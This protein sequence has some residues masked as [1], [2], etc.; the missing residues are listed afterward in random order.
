[1]TVSVA[2]GVAQDL[3]GNPNLASNTAT[4]Q[5]VVAPGALTLDLPNNITRNNDP[6]QP[7]AVV[8]FTATASGGVP[9]VVVVCDP[10]SGAFFAIGAT[11]VTCI[12]TDG[13]E[14]QQ[15]EAIVS[16]TFTVTVVDVEPP[17]I[18]DLPDLT[19]TT[20]DTTPVA[21]L[22]PL[23]AASDNSGVPPTVSCSPGS[24]TAFPVGVTTVTCTATDGAGLTA[25]SSF[26]VTVT[27]TPAQPPA[28][29]TPGGGLP[30]TGSSSTTHMLMLATLLVGVGLALRGGRRRW[31]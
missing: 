9:P 17:T 2:A 25:T 29:T 10:A 20:T 24:G 27:S 23:P 22:F 21:V 26:T 8:A 30:A 18:A 14:G 16:G 12:A 28:P 15:D 31:M 1:V 4:V 5:Y 3:A 6:G 7:G 11:T 13:E 19:R